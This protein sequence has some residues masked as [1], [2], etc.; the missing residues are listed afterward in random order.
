MVNYL[1]FKDIHL[2]SEINPLFRFKNAGAYVRLYRVRGQG[3]TFQHLQTPK[4]ITLFSKKK[5][6]FCME[7]TPLFTKL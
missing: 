1:S 2:L 6:R 7:I 3:H 5:S 4:H